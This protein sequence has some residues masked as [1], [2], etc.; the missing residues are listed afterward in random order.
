M[1]QAAIGSAPGTASAVLAD[2]IANLLQP[3]TSPVILTSLAYRA[4]GDVQSLL[5]RAVP[6]RSAAH[7]IP[8]RIASGEHALFSAEVCVT[9]AA[10][11]TGCNR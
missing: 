10:N 6:K 1:D 8:H 2:V 11:V 9:D 5:F 3:L 7:R 4:F